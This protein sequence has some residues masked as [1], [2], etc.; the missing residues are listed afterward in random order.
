MEK[1]S[2]KTPVM[3]QQP[4]QPAGSEVV[5]VAEEK[6]KDLTMKQ[7]LTKKW[8]IWIIVFPI[9][10]YTSFLLA[11]AVVVGTMRLLSVL[12]ISL[13]F[14][15]EALAVTV[16][17]SIIFALAAGIVVAVPYWL[18]RDRTSL[19]DIGLPDTPRFM[20]IFLALLIFFV[21]LIVSGIIMAIVTGPLGF[22]LETRQQLPFSSDMLLTQWQYWMAFVTLVV[23]APLA[24]EVLFRGYL[25]GKL[26]KF[27]PIWVSVLAASVTFGLAHLWA[28][29]SPLQVMVAIDT[30]VLSLFLCLLREHTGAIWASFIV[31]AIKNGLAFYLLFVNPDIINEI[32]TAIMRLF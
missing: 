32:N 14:S 24:E 10:T 31:H 9:W 11:Q 7:K 4:E 29:D 20:D 2:K 21:Y 6:K 1:L 15:N 3:K 22:K 13:N 23:V 16:L 28:P 18:F 26:R 5:K 17:T 27:A 25:Y 30:F 12:N 19:K 8:W